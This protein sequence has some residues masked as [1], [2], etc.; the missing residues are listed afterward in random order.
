MS[1][2][3]SLTREELVRLITRKVIEALQGGRPIPLGVSNRH[4]HLNLREAYAGGEAVVLAVAGGLRRDVDQVS[5]DGHDAHAHKHVLSD[6]DRP[7]VVHL[8]L[9]GRGDAL[10]GL[11]AIGQAAHGLV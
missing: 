2:T 5:G 4:I 1:T 3:R 8:E 6:R 11:A 9:D 7:H 10:A